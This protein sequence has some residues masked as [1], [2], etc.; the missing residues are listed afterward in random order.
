VTAPALARTIGDHLTVVAALVDGLLFVVVHAD[1]GARSAVRGTVVQ[2]L[3]ELS[4][5][6]VADAEAT[7]VIVVPD[8]VDAAL[9]ERVAAKV[10]VA[11]QV[12][13]GGVD[14]QTVR[15]RVVDVGDLLGVTRKLDMVVVCGRVP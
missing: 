4:A 14:R 15:L 3:G 7:E 9:V 8:L 13:Q 1:R 12:V 6:F 2:V 5:V 10:P 11:V